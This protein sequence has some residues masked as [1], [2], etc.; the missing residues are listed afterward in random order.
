VRMTTKHR[1]RSPTLLWTAA[2]LPQ[3]LRNSNKSKRPAF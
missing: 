1:L 3:P 2:R